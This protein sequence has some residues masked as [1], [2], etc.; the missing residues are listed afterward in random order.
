MINM[1]KGWNNMDRLLSGLPENIYKI[2]QT[3]FE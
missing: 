3:N 2:G 1:F